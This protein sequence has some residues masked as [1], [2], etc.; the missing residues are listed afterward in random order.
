MDEVKDRASNRQLI[1]IIKFKKETKSE[2]WQLDWC[3]VVVPKG[4]DQTQTL[5]AR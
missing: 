3:G 5:A 4:P 1:P 2:N